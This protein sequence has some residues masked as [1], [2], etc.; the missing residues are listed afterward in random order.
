MEQWS[1][2]LSEAERRVLAMHCFDHVVA[3]CE[4]CHRSFTLTQMGVD[5]LAPRRHHFCPLCRADLTHAV[6]LH[7]LTCTAI[8]AAL[9]EVSERTHQRVKD[10]QRLLGQSELLAAESQT[11]AQRV[12]RLENRSS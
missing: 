2:V 5:V 3:T 1:A 4:R 10:S 12:L 6:R 8:A 11:R 9:G 7:I